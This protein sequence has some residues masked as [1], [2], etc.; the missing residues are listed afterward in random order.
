[1]GTYISYVKSVY[2]FHSGVELQ[3][4]GPDLGLILKGFKRVAQHRVTPVDTLLPDDIVLLSPHINRSDIRGKAF[5]AALLLVFF[6]FFRSSTLMPGKKTF[7]GF[8]HLLREDVQVMDE[9]LLVSMR[10]S[11]ARQFNDVVLNFPIPRHHSSLFC[12]YRAWVDLISTC[13]IDGRAPAFSW[14]INKLFYYTIFSNE[15]KYCC[16]AV[17]LPN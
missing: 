3:K 12:P 13:Q 8:N 5:W 9:F 2:L 4:F 10:F 6:T 1:V 11:K 15:L 16:F 14:G 7:R 17:L